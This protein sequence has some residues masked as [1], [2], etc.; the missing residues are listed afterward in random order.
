MLSEK[1]E[2]SQASIALEISQLTEVEL[3]TKL[4]SES[5]VLSS[6][7]SIFFDKVLISRVH[8]VDLNKHI[9]RGAP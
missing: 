2:E 3:L 7:A 4:W 6:G 9:L 5:I 8:I 1:E